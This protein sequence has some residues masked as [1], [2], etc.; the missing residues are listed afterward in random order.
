MKRYYSTQRPVSLGTYPKP[1]GNKVLDVENFDE[2]T[3]CEP[4]GRMA[5][6]YIDYEQPLSEQDAENYDLVEA[7]RQK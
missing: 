5:W 7:G 1:R 6:G 4:V 3:Y 2:R